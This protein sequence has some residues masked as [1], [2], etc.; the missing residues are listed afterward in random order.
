MRPIGRARYG[1]LSFSPV[2]GSIWTAH[3]ETMQA[4]N[5]IAEELNH[6]PITLLD[7]WRFVMQ[8]IP[9]KR[10]T[11]ADLRC[12]VAIVDCYNS[13]KG[14]AWPSYTY[15]SQKTGLSRSA[16]AR[17]VKK[18]DALGII[19]KVSV[20]TG[21]ANT[22]HPV[23]C[24]S[25]AKTVTPETGGTCVTHETGLKHE[26]SAKDETTPV[27]HVTPDPSHRCDT[28]PLNPRSN[29]V[30]DYR[31]IPTVGGAARAGGALR[32]LGGAPTND[33]FEAFWSSYPKRE[34]R[35]LAK[36]A[37]SRVIAG[38]VAPDIL[39][40][41]ARQYAEAKADVDAKWLKMP[42]NWLKEECWL[43]DPRPASQSSGRA[44]APSG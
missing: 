39:I 17:S 16:I 44:Q 26:T 20:G 3:K 27:S 14:R 15:I 33:G 38:G 8:A 29:S 18:L 12:L 5:T 1:S 6:K 25:P 2:Q 10:L 7:K 4:M 11:A 22:Y 24:K 42:A 30:G 35:S 36:Q 21:R 23:F 19:D 31:G 34:G 32:P 40:A 37:Y 43:E 13:S 41:K 9:N 28:I